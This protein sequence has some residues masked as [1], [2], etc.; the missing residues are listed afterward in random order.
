[1]CTKYMSIIILSIILLCLVA[2]QFYQQYCAKSKEGYE[3]MQTC[4]AR[5]NDVHDEYQKVYSPE[6]AQMKEK[7]SCDK[8][9]AMEQ[10]ESYKSCMRRNYWDDC[11]RKLKDCDRY[12]EM[13]RKCTNRECFDRFNDYKKHCQEPCSWQMAYCTQM[14]REELLP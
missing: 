4:Q 11:P 2:Y 1:M 7:A 6:Y 13:L 10:S 8:Q 12:D 3:T 9:S 14:V 5:A